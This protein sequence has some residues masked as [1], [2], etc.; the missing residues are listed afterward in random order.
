M[1]NVVGVSI[2]A[3][4]TTM[5]FSGPMKSRFRIGRVIA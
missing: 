1:A 4:K 2:L 5:R 3:E